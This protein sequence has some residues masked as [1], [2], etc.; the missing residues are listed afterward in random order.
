LDERGELR[1]LVAAKLDLIPRKSAEQRESIL[2]VKRY[3]E[4]AAVSQNV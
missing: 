4:S 1:H 3:W 2:A